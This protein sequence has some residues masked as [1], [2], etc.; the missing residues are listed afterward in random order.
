[1]GIFDSPPEKFQGSVREEYQELHAIRAYFESGAQYKHWFDAEY[2]SVYLKAYKAY[3]EIGVEQQRK[4]ALKDLGLDDSHWMSK[5]IAKRLDKRLDAVLP[6]LRED[7]KKAADVKARSLAEKYARGKEQALLMPVIHRFLTAIRDE[8]TRLLSVVSWFDQ[9]QRQMLDPNQ[10]VH[11]EGIRDHPV[12]SVDANI[13]QVFTN[14][15]AQVFDRKLEWALIFQ[16]D[17]YKY[18]S[19]ESRAR[20]ALGFISDFEKVG[21][22]FLKLLADVILFVHSKQDFNSNPEKFTKS[23]LVALLQRYG[24]LGTIIDRYRD[25]TP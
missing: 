17:L 12:L 23:V 20:Y 2:K 25:L 1:M 24:A 8:R 13:R 9:G 16:T 14:R 10:R 21:G 5:E 19:F 11:F 6:K 7:A 4:L 3:F 18:S 22:G 15:S